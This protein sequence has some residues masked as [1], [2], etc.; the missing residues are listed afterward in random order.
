MSDK[1][2]DNPLVNEMINTL[3]KFATDNSITQLYLYV[4]TSDDRA[5]RSIQIAAP[6][7]DKFV[8]K[9]RRPQ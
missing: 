1:S 6:S 7:S 3:Q 4:E 8:E 5:T 9:Y 2:K